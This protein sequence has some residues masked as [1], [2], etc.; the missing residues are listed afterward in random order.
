V[1]FAF[2]EKLFDTGKFVASLGTEYPILYVQYTRGLTGILN[3]NYAYNKIDVKAEK[4][5]TLRGLG[6]PSMVLYAGYID[7]PSPYILN[8]TTRSA[9]GPN[10]YV[11]SMYSYETMRM[12]EFLSDT[13]VSL[14]F[15]H[16]FQTLL[17]KSKKF[18]PQFVLIHNMGWGMLSHPERQ[19]GIQF[20]TMEKGYFESGLLINDI[21]K[22]GLS[23]IG[24]GAYYRYGPNSLPTWNNNIAIKLSLSLNF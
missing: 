11:A 24:I 15:R 4:T 22:T 12:N 21:Y 14:F 13:Y 16:N 6:K 10:P 19:Q 1:R 17:Y 20:K 18:R 3:G 2:K 7:R 9:Y 23:G 8:Y 5:F